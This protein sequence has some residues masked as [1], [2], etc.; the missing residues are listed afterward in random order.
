MQVAF[1]S[2]DLDGLLE[3]IP[4]MEDG[5]VQGVLLFQALQTQ[6][7]ADD[8]GDALQDFEKG[9][10]TMF[11]QA[12]FLDGMVEVNSPV[13]PK[14][15]MDVVQTFMSLDLTA[16]KEIASAVLDKWSEVMEIYKLVK[17]AILG[18]D[19]EDGEEKKEEEKD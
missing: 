10:M 14:R 9:V 15:I 12:S 13:D 16:R 7:F 11:W 17:E 4:K 8:F 6:E 19:G 18:E 2:M 1:Q 3:S 5:R